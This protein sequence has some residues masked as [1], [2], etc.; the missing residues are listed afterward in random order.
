[1]CIRDSSEGTNDKGFS[2]MTVAGVLVG[3]LILLAA[4]LVIY[5]I[6]KISVSKRIKEMCIRDSA[7]NDHT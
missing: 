7:G 5:N 4:G 3:T 2:F 1:M 6:L